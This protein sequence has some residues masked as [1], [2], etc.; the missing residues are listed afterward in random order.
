MKE[1]SRRSFLKG[2]TASAISAASLGAL[3]GISL[4]EEA[5][6]EGLMTVNGFQKIQETVITVK[7]R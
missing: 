4:A 6:T 3:G 5:A 7:K 2:L 1:L